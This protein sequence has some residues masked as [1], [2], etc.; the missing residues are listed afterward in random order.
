V[1]IGDF[2][3]EKRKDKGI[4]ARE[5]ARRSGVSQPYLSQLEN[6]KN[7]KPSPNILNKIAEVLEIPNGTVM[8]VAGYIE[9]PFNPV[10]HK[11]LTD[12]LEIEDI[13]ELLETKEKVSYN[14]KVLTDE[15][16]KRAIGILDALFN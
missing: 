2:I 14:G 4:S 1:G 9:D 11:N 8:L 12:Q 15:E 3:K 5:L 16:R 6:G 10:Q 13:K 7:D